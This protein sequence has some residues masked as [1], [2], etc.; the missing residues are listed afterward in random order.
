M[1]KRPD[2]VRNL[3]S[4][5]LTRRRFLYLGGASA[6]TLTVAAL[7]PR[8]PNLASTGASAVQLQEYPRTRIA[9]LSSLVVDEAVDF[10]YPYDSVRNV[11]LK[12]GVP[13]GGG[14]GPESDVVA[15]NTLCTHMGGPLQPNLAADYKILGPCPFHLSTFDMTRHG[16]IVAGHAT[17]GLPQIVL[18][19]DGDD[20]YATGVLSLLY[21][22]SDNKLPPST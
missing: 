3:L 18:E 21:G 12:L 16:M 8:F 15:F 20:I 5:A 9:S 1:T 7:L 4:C 14:I 13:A 19:L 11:L 22:F 17:A 2:P 6:A 10:T